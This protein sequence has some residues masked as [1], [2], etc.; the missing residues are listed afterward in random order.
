VAIHLWTS[1]SLLTCQVDENA[2]IVLN[3]LCTDL[4]Y[5]A[6][7]V[8]IVIMDTDEQVG[9]DPSNHYVSANSIPTSRSD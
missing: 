1:I 3:S 2:R 5:L 7:I 9:K 4:T 8:E 6:I